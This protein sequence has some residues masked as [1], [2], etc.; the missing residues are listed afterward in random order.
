MGAR[1]FVDYVTEATGG[2]VEFEI[3]HSAQLGD[4]SLALLSSGLADIALMS[5]GYAADRMPLSNVTELP[6]MFDSACDANR[7]FRQ[8]ASPGGALYEN[9]YKGL[10]LHPVYMAMSPPASIVMGKGKVERWSD[11][12]GMKLRASGGGA[13]AIA[14]AIGSVPVQTVASELYDSL[15]RG[16]I[17]GALYYFVGMPSFSLEEVFHSGVG[18]LKLGASSVFTAMSEKGWNKLP[19]D[20]QQAMVEGGAK[21]EQSLCGWFDQNEASIRDEMVRDRGFVVTELPPE[22]LEK[23]QAVRVRIAEDWV[24]I[25]EQKGRKGTDVLNDFRSAE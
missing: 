13:S 18:N 22:D 17:D 8:I 21:A 4:D 5:T 10:G 15:E 6:G 9:E 20:V 2:K 14:R 24:K 19:P 23:W 12:Q 25:M 11:L 3:Y 16:T 1:F 7:K